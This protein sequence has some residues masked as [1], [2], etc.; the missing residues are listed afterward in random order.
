MLEHR[1]FV[2]Y[3]MVYEPA[4]ELKARDDQVHDRI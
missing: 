1:S 2:A 3:G 4:T